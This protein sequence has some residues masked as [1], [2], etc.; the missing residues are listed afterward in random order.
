MKKPRDLGIHLNTYCSISL[1]VINW[2]GP[3]QNVANFEYKIIGKINCKREL[4]KKVTL[5]LQYNTSLNN[6]AV[7]RGSARLMSTC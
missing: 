5:I 7:P 6:A 1:P 4:A 3:V 2:S